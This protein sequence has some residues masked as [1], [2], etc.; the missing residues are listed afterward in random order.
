MKRIFLFLFIFF[1]ATQLWAGSPIHLEGMVADSR[2][3]SWAF[4]QIRALGQDGRKDVGKTTANHKGQFSF[5]VKGI[6]GTLLFAN[7][8]AG[9]IA[10]E[11]GPWK[12]NAYIDVMFGVLDLFTISGRVIDD[13]N[14]LMERVTDP[15]ANRDGDFDHNTRQVV[16]PMFLA[17]VGH[18]VWSPWGL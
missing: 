1:W 16:S 6:V 10:R 11:K 12:K 13:N 7:I 3:R 14:I 2:G 5:Q 9:I 8:K 4:C 15:G 18:M 17:G